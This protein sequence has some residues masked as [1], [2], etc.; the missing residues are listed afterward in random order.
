M[1]AHKYLGCAICQVWR[2]KNVIKPAP[3]KRNCN[4]KN[5]VYHKQIGLGMF[6]QMTKQVYL[7]QMSKCNHVWKCKMSLTNPVLFLFQVCE[8]CPNVKY[9]REG[10]FVTVDIEKGM[11]DG[12]VSNPPSS[13]KFSSKFQRSF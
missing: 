7:S 11:Q 4:C 1:A 6:Q 2:V 13:S 9:E 8:K 10:D 3:G 12:Q 5:E